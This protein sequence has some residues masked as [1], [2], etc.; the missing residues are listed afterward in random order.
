MKNITTATFLLCLVF[1]AVAA[2]RVIV[3]PDNQQNQQ[4]VTKAISQA[5]RSVDIVIYD[6][7]AEDILKAL[8]TA[9]A[10]LAKNNP[11][12][13]AI[14][15][16]INSQWYG[17]TGA[18][19]QAKYWSIMMQQ[20][21]VDMKTGRS[22][23]GVVQFNYSSNNFQIT[24]QKTILIDARRKDGS[25]YARPSQLPASAKA[26][27]ATF[28]LQAYQW[29]ATYTGPTPGSNCPQNPNCSFAANTRDFG[30][31]VHDQKQ[32]W[33]I[34]RIF[35]SDFAGPTPFES[36]NQF[37]LN[38]SGNALVWSN[39]T[40]G[41]TS[42]QPPDFGVVF[43]PAR[44]AYPAFSGAS[45][46][47]GFYPYPPTE[48]AIDS[49]IFPNQVN[50]GQVAGNARG[51]LIDLINRAASY[52]QQGQEPSLLIYNEE[53]SDPQILTAINR[54]ASMGVNIRIVMSFNKNYG[55]GYQSL[56]TTTRASGGPVD[57]TVHL[58]PTT[59]SYMYIHAKM[60]YLDLPGLVNDLVVIS[61][62]NISPTS[63][64][65]NRELGL[66]LGKAWRNLSADAAKK[67]ISTFNKDYSYLG[68]EGTACPIVL[69]S[70]TNT[71]NAQV[72]ALDNNGCVAVAGTTT[73]IAGAKP[74]VDSTASTFPAP[75]LKVHSSYSPPLPQGNPLNL[76]MAGYA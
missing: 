2:P 61:S 20:L 56:V 52:A 25:E 74:I 36:N 19:A 47:S 15:V 33:L 38:D 62:Q 11:M 45:I 34:E 26:I 1:T 23:D 9:K 67:L 21:G 75:L 44:N 18:S 28:N 68:N 7:G 71:W 72:D 70:P 50:P 6:F 76:R 51:I 57:A 58:Y 8:I 32:I 24:H 49:Q 64:D 14:R 5:K 29:P 22:S 16:M 55:D 73:R 46:G 35:S 10:K 42:P 43:S 60:L 30:L 53:Y 17:Q 12:M 3:Q 65:Q 54:A 27:V 66:R 13:P 59:A 63:L 41:V 40:L 37:G 48:F 31:F 4:D 69:I 39:G